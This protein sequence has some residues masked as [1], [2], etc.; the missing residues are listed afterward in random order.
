MRSI[1]TSLGREATACLS[2]N[3]VLESPPEQESLVLGDPWIATIFI[4]PWLFCVASA[5]Y[6]KNVIIIFYLVEIIDICVF[7]ESI[8][9]RSLV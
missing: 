6:S 3:A 1:F 2:R 9:T 4:L 8:F 7:V 5:K